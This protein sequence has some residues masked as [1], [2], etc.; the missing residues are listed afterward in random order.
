MHRQV[1][2]MYALQ[3]GPCT[4]AARDTGD[5]GILPGG[6]EMQVWQQ[7]IHA[8]TMT[9]NIE[10]SLCIMLLFLFKFIIKLIIFILV[11]I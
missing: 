4:G 8:M 7:V 11:I 5:G 6:M 10:I 3:T 9:M 2:E 1:W